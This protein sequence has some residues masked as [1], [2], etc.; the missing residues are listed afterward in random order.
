MIE[1]VLLAKFDPIIFLMIVYDSFPIALDQ[2]ICARVSISD[3]K[4]LIH[5]YMYV[6]GEG[7]HESLGA[8]LI[9]SSLFWMC[10]SHQVCI[11][12]AISCL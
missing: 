5:I 7:A 3:G 8:L 10:K 6:H 2:K 12:R 1:Y 11:G 9:E 4:M